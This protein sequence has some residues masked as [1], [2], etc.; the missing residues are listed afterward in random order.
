MK[1]TSKVVS[2]LLTGLLAPTGGAALA[3]DSAELAQQELEAFLEDWNRE[4]NEALL[5]HLSFPHV[6]H[7]A[8]PSTTSRRSRYRRPRSISWSISVVT[9]KMTRSMPTCRCST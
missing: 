4:D 8:A 1:T 9:M 3:Q 5:D 6:T 7:R 2:V